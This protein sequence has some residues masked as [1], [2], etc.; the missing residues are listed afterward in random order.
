MGHASPPPQV[1]PTL[2]AKTLG[3]STPEIKMGG[4]GGA[5][6]SLPLLTW[7]PGLAQ[8]ALHGPGLWVLRLGRIALHS[9]Q[10][11]L[12]WLAHHLPPPARKPLLQTPAPPPTVLSPYRLQS[13]LPLSG[14]LSNSG[15]PLFSYS[16]S[17]VL[18]NSPP[19]VSSILPSLLPIPAA[20][21]GLFFLR[22][23]PLT[24]SLAVAV[25]SLKLLFPPSLELA[26]PVPL[27]IPPAPSLP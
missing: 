15:L 10:A 20:V 11:S 17:P 26:P 6:T 13:V 16:L 23:P 14:D 12:C 22:R 1:H 7:A 27:N 3:S 5:A 18:S 2:C 4:A 19:R 8:A 21:A 25:P 9:S 24:L